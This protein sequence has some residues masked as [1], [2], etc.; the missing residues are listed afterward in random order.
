MANLQA[1]LILLVF[2]VA[3]GLM[4]TRKMPAL[5][6]LPAMAIAI[7][8][9]AGMGLRD[10][11]ETVI[12]KGAMRLSGAIAAAIFGG[13][14]AQVVRRAGIA[15]SL[16]KRAAELSGENALWVSLALGLA[17][18][19]LFTALGGIGAVILV[20]SLVFPVLLAV[21]VRPLAAAGLF[22]LSMSVGGMLNVANWQFYIDTLKLPQSE[23]RAFALWLFVPGVL[24]V[25][26]YIL[27]AI[28]GKRSR[29]M[30][31]ETPSEEVRRVPSLAY[32]TPLL[33]VL[34]IL[35]MPLARIVLGAIAAR[36]G[37]TIEAMYGDFATW[38][39]PIVPAML[40]GVLWGVATAPKQASGRVQLLTASTVEGIKD[41][42]PAVGLM[43]G[44]GMLFLAVTSDPVKN[45]LIHLDPE[46]GIASGPLALL[47]IGSPW[48]FVLA[49][50]LLAPLALWRGPLNV[51][52]MGI[53]IAGVL[54]AG[55]VLPAGAAM[56]GLMA[57]GQVQ[58]VCD[59]T[60]THNVWVASNLGVDVHD[61]L[62]KTLPYA[63]GL[64][65]AG[66]MIGAVIAFP[67]A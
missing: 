52:G 1:P 60:N 56:A 3:A 48:V 58:G 12:D 61:I 27:L 16:V 24:A 47:R 35:S 29:R 53:G 20:A 46:T 32:L 7:A 41:V 50:G 9:V 30:W 10:V 64:A 18:V 19:L 17:C 45:C 5:L 23:V 66:L 43:I 65:I 63:W 6:A 14:L 36:S 59:P 22:L 54:V 55:G 40:L 51:W 2:A 21:G 37:S 31:A 15:E 4:M 13:I 11:L 42:A 39:F 34:L 25:L 62:K 26:V 57:V 49:W 28:A 67:R 38:E 33:P 8:L 44:I